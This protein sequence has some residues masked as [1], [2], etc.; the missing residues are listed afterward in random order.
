MAAGGTRVTGLAAGR[1]LAVTH[2]AD[3]AR[4]AVLQARGRGGR[5]PQGWVSRSYGSFEPAPALG[6]TGHARG[7]WRAATLFEL[8]EPGATPALALRREGG[9]VV[10]EGAGDLDTGAPQP[11]YLRPR[12][13]GGPSLMALMKVAARLMQTRFPYMINKIPVW[14]RVPRCG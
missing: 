8:V 11:R 7:D 3:G 4:R 5:C 12:H 1:S 2:V 13:R 10:L 9:R 14:A 6:F